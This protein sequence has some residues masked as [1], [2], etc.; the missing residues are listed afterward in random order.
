MYSTL[1]LQLYFPRR[2]SLITNESYYYQ[3]LTDKLVLKNYS[4]MLHFFIPTSYFPKS[5]DLSFRMDQKHSKTNMHV[6]TIT[7]SG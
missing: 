7:L 3:R 4:P 5:F 6:A 2:K 1:E